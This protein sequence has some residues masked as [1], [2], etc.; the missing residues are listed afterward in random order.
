MYVGMIQLTYTGSEEVRQDRK[1]AVSWAFENIDNTK[2]TVA[3]EKFGN[4]EHIWPH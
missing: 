1:T 4:V 3:C 2:A